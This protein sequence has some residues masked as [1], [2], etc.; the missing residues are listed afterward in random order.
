MIR[1]P[2]SR[3]HMKPFLQQEQLCFNTL[4]KLNIR[5]AA[6]GVRQPSVS[7]KKRALLTGDGQR[8]GHS[9]RSTGQ[10][11]RLLLKVVNSWPSVTANQ[12]VVEGANVSSWVSIAQH[13]AVANV[14]RASTLKTLWWAWSLS[15]TVMTS[16]PSL[17]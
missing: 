1:L 15:S 5:Q 7:H 11:M 9:G 6:Y 16:A 4:N 14:N 12:S 13:C 3:G 10:Q 17:I 2:E 8:S